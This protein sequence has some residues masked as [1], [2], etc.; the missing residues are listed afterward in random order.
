MSYYKSDEGKDDAGGT[1]TLKS[2]TL[3]MFNNQWMLTCVEPT[4][5][6]EW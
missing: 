4:F 5:A 2:S 1:F 3:Q 6:L